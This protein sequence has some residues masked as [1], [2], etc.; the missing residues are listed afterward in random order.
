M[1]GSYYREATQ[2]ALL[3]LFAEIT[4][5]PL[6]LYE[7]HNRE[8]KGI[9]TERALGNFEPHCKL[10]H[11]FQD[12]KAR[13]EQ[14]QCDRALAVFTSQQEQSGLCHAGL[15]NEAV[16]IKVRGQTRAVLLYG[17]TQ[18]EGQQDAVLQK[19]QAAVA[20]LGLS[21]QQA[22]QLRQRLSQVKTYSPQKM[23]MFKATLVKLK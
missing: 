2:K 9:Y 10:L 20:E 17:E 3:E 13:C 19:H 16:P 7:L 18:I 15:H 6:V 11:T 1:S 21:K 8:P 23:A 12:G 4:D 14:D 5:L 22:G